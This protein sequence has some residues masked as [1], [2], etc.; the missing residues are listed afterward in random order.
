[1]SQIIWTPNALRCVQRLHNFLKDKNPSSAQR[2]I[3]AVRDGVTI[4]KSF[5]NAGRLVKDV[6]GEYRQWPIAFGKTSYAVLY[7]YDEKEITI[8][9][10][11]HQSELNFKF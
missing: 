8:L 3:K 10:V 2:V 1:V 9:S 7:K 6:G 5:P 11:K 4:L